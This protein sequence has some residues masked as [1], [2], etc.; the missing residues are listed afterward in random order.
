MSALSKFCLCNEKKIKV[1]LEKEYTAFQSA[2]GIPIICVTLVRR[3]LLFRLRFH[4]L[5]GAVTGVVEV[6]FPRASWTAVP[7]TC[8]VLLS[9]STSEWYQGLK[10]EE[11]RQTFSR[12]LSSPENP[13][14]ICG[15]W[16]GPRRRN[17]KQPRGRAVLC[18]RSALSEAAVRR[19]RASRFA[20]RAPAHTVCSGCLGK[21]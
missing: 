20:K 10:S 2:V 9:N 5:E 12:L 3:P 8:Y 6:T 13:P 7:S 1:S 15:S 16:C 11:P 14:G 18:E 17:A 4:V 19:A 21:L